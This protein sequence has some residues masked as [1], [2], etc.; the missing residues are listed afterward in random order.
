MIPNNGYIE[1]VAT[2]SVEKVMNVIERI[3]AAEI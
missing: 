2:E 1:S 3:L